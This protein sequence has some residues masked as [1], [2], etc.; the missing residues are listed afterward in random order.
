M[1]RLLM[2]LPV[3]HWHQPR[4]YKAI[5]EKAVRQADTAQLLASRCDG[6]S[7]K[8]RQSF[9]RELYVSWPGESPC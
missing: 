8:W 3:K 7:A 5:S 6:L 4:L 2:T 9:D 1:L